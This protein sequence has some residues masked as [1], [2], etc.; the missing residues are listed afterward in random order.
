MDLGGRNSVGRAE[1]V[2]QV[3]DGVAVLPKI[4][5]RRQEYSSLCQGLGRYHYPD[6]V[7]YSSIQVICTSIA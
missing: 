6:I 4:D 7:S 2:F 5:L 3:G 1:D